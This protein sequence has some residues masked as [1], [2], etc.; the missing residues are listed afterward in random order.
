[1]TSWLHQQR[2]GAVHA[3]VKA[4]GARSVLDLGCGD[5]HLITRLAEDPQIDRIVGIDLSLDALE[6]LRSRLRAAQ[7]ERRA[8]IELIHGSMTEAGLAFTDFDVAVLIET[9]EH[10]EPGRL[11]ALERAVFHTMHPAT[12]VIT[13]PNADFNRLLGVPSHRFRH[14]DHR[15]EWDRA[16]FQRWVRGVATRNG[17]DAAC[18][19]VGGRHPA[20]GGASQ[21]AVFDRAASRPGHRLAA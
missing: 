4:S 10:I 13:T 21:M 14:P 12:V 8:R 16:K 7:E 1:M 9:L 6:R 11:S 19:D 2:V 18:H 3:A 20:L 17:Y 5:G 15:F